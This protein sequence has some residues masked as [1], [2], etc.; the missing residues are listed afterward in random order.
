MRLSIAALII[1]FFA[2]AIALAAQTGTDATR[3]DADAAAMED[4]IRPYDFV[5]CPKGASAAH[6]AS[7]QRIADIL[8]VKLILQQ[9]VNPVCCTWVEV[10]RWTPNP[11]QR[12]YLINN[13]GGGSLISAS[14]E[15]QLQAAVDRFIASI[16]TING[17]VHVPSGLMTNYRLAAG[18]GG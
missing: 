13:Q 15:E 18:A 12:G 1:A 17:K 7:A 6:K 8:G 11:G 2:G 4:Y 3:S 16:H 9:N 10:N 14:D 5:G